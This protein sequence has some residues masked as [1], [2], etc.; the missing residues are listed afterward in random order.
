M[1]YHHLR[2]CDWG[3]TRRTRV[4]TAVTPTLRITIVATIIRTV[5]APAVGK[6]RLRQCIPGEQETARQHKYYR[7]NK[8]PRFELH[9]NLL[10]MFLSARTEPTRQ[11]FTS[12]QPRNQE[13]SICHFGL[14]K[15]FAILDSLRVDSFVGGRVTIQSVSARRTAPV[16]T[17]PTVR[18]RDMYPPLRN[19]ECVNVMQRKSLAEGKA[20]GS[21]TL[22]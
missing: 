14:L 12:R 11:Q 2:S 7:D 17:K 15:R 3:A 18:R 21:E 5:F 20:S 9:E 1:A 22:L 8:K 6:A 13:N 4:R 19:E 16:S 10:L